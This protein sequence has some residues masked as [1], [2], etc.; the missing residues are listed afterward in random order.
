MKENRRRGQNTYNKAKITRRTYTAYVCSYIFP[1]GSSITPQPNLK[2]YLRSPSSAKNTNA[3]HYPSNTNSEVQNG[4][5]TSVVHQNI[6]LLHLSFDV[7]C[8]V[9]KCSHS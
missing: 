6:A 9:C 7:L 5:Y 8:G 1:K 4:N 2:I 3:T